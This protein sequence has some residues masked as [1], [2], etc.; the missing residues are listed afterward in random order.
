MKTLRIVPFI[1][2][3]ITF[4]QF[5]FAQKQ[6]TETLKIAGECGMCKKKI[7]TAAKDAGATYAVWNTDSKILTVKYNSQSTNSAKIQQ[8]IADAG[9]DTPK[10]R[11]A[12]EAYNNLEQCCQ[13]D[14]QPANTDNKNVAMQC[15]MKD[16]KCVNE[17]ACKDK[18]CCADPAK[19]KDMGC[20]GNGM[21]MNG[22][23]NMGQKN[24]GGKMAMNCSDD[25]SCCQKK[26]GQ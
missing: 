1:A 16:G 23:M 22:K 3:F 26:T 10:F 11:A 8:K 6:A 18:G 14:R 4:T 7:E 12:D 21:S 9:Y 17:A 5:G 15:E 24:T 20:G 19:C 13:Y 2:I 25:K